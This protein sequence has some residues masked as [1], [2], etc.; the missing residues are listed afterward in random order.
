VD[1][2]LNRNLSAVAQL[3]FKGTA[4]TLAPMSL[5]MLQGGNVTYRTDDVAPGKYADD[6]FRY[7]GVVANPWRAWRETMPVV[8]ALE[9]GAD[10]L[11]D[12][13]ARGDHGSDSR[14]DAMTIVGEVIT[15][16]HAKEQL[17]LTNDTSPYLY[18][19]VTLP[20]AS[21]ERSHSLTLQTLNAQ[22][23]VVFVDDVLVADLYD[24][25]DGL[26]DDGVVLTCNFTV[27]A[28]PYHRLSIL[29]SSLGVQNFYPAGYCMWKGLAGGNESCRNHPDSV[30]GQ[31]P[32][33][34]DGAPMW[35]PDWT[36]T[37]RPRLQGEWLN[38]TAAAAPTH[39]LKNDGIID[40][41]PPPPVVQWELAEAKI[42]QPKTW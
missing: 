1:F 32:P 14:S 7:A 23:F 33:L 20:G 10:H 30:A 15:A 5:V 35:G 37:M 18:Y 9:S 29:S 26:Q 25:T 11:G 38:I 22:A 13:A 16:D 6:G 12:D 2:I 27:A 4:L 36:W 8:P 28:A 40:Q 24:S 17:A 3:Q 31:A 21:A 41:A 19:E 39:N 42:K 34:L